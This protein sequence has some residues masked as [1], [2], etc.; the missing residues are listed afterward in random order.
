VFAV[1]AANAVGEG[2]RSTRSKAVRPR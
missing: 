1:S 2:P